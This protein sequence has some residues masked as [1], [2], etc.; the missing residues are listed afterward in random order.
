MTLR[1]LQTKLDAVLLEFITKNEANLE[2]VF[3]ASIILRNA[4]HGMA[5]TAIDFGL[6]SAGI[7]RATKAAE[8]SDARLWGDVF[9]V[10]TAKG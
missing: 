9:G 8:D 4:S 5:V 7:A 1:E 3:A 6:D 2:D 10:K